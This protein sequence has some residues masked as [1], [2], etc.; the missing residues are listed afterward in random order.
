MPYLFGRD[1]TRAELESRVGRLD[2]V[3]GVTPLAMQAGRGVGVRALEF[4]TG[5]GFAFTALIDR[6]FDVAFARYGGI[7]LCWRSCN[8]VASPAYY[9]PHGDAFLRTFLGGLFTTCGLTN[10][11]PAGQDE[12]GEFGLHGR[13]DATP[14]ENVAHQAIWD[15]DEC[16]L[17]ARGTF[18]ETR[19]FGENMRLERRLRAPLG[20]RSL[21]LHDE[22]TNDG[23]SRTPHMLLYHC[24]G[25]FPILAEGAE[26]HV[27]HS[28]MRP[29]DAQA[30]RA[31]TQWSQ[32]GPPDPN[33]KEQVFIH[34]PVTCND[35]LAAAVLINP[36]LRAGRG[37][38]LAIRFDPAQLP[39]LFTWR[40]L[41]CGTYVMGME[42]ANCP[43]IEGRVEAGKRGT[44]PFLEPGETRSYDLRFDV[45]E[46]SEEVAAMLA[47]FPAP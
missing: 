36:A 25:G 15:G 27:S 1:Y 32:G 2:A 40:M 19:V 46:S 23:G 18:R 44:L 39:A 45:L 41:G 16:M 7:P 8:D 38:A 12:W 14:A 43:T 47:R 9:D 42:P 17:E 31:L 33:F 6:A 29:R 5:S 24:N 37:L 35:G 4:D 26:L 11:G 3:G 13:I 34:T 30:E 20:G 10:F 21:E 22:V 28:G